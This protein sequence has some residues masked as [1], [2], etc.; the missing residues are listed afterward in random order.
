TVCKADPLAVVRG[1]LRQ[2]RDGDKTVVDINGY[3]I[4]KELG[5]GGMGAVF[6]AEHTPT[7]EPVALKV[8]LPRVAAGERARRM[9]LREAENT[10][11]LRHPNVVRFRDVGCSGGAFFLTLEY[12][13]GGNVA[14]L[15][16]RRG[17]PLAVDEA[18]AIVLPALDGLE[19]AHQAEVPLVKRP[20][21]SFGPGRGLIHRDLKPSNLLLC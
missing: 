13:D 8:L 17:A 3:E 7:G 14:E 11:A 16:K 18:L 4:R 6:L 2:A 21:G 19:Y 1:L 5:R 20:D 10:K 15:L 12:C 9:C